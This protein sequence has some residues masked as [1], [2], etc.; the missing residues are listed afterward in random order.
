MNHVLKRYFSQENCG[1]DEGQGKSSF[2]AFEANDDCKLFWSQPLRDKHRSRLVDT[3]GFSCCY[4]VCQKRSSREGIFL[5]PLPHQTDFCDTH[6]WG[7][8]FCRRFSTQHDGDPLLYCISQPYLFSRSTCSPTVLPWKG[9]LF[10]ERPWSALVH[11][12][13]KRYLAIPCRISQSRERLLHRLPTFSR[14]QSWI[15][16]VFH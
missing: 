11:T 15:L 1:S 6:H 16:R 2:E 3:A 10:Q 14:L 13:L 9:I 7:V 8:C 5:Y 4:D 12:L